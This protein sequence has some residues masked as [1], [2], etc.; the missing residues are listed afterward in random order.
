MAAPVRI[1]ELAA[2]GSLTASAAVA[3]VQGNDTVQKAASTFI[4]EAES[5]T[6]SG[7]GAASRTAQAKLRDVVSIK[8][9]GVNGD[10]SDETVNIQK[11]IDATKSTSLA[12]AR[13][14]Y[15][16]AGDYAASNLS[17][18]GYFKWLGDGWGTRLVALNTGSSAYFIASSQ[19]TTA[20]QTTADLP[21][22]MQDLYIDA[23]GFKTNC[24]VVRSFYTMLEN[25]YIRG[26]IDTDLL[27]S[28]A[29]SDGTQIAG[30]M[31]NGRIRSCW[32][33]PDGGTDPEYN[34]RTND[35][36][37][38][39]TDW[40]IDGTY[41]SG[42]DT[43]NLFIENCAGWVVRGNHFYGATQ[44]WTI[45]RADFTFICQGNIFDG[46]DVEIG[47]G[48]SGQPNMVFGPGNQLNDADVIASFGVNGSNIYSIGNKY[49]NGQIIHNFSSAAKTLISMDDVFNNATP[50]S[51]AGAGLVKTYN[52]YNASTSRR[53]N[54]Q[55]SWTPTIT[56]GGAST[57]ITYAAQTGTYT[58]EGNR[59]KVQGRIVLSSKG[60]LTGNVQIA[61][62]PFT[63]ANTADQNGAGGS[64]TYWDLTG[65]T[66]HPVLIGQLNTTRIT[67]QEAAAD[68]PTLVDEANLKNN[69]ELSFNYEYRMA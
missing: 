33:G 26:S 51:N 47:N 8:D 69:T 61:S 52:S 48:N 66:A 62:L 4:T 9:F 16:P 34:I 27:I 7:T 68:V 17:I 39:V 42:A 35:P 14:L 15:W 1:D 67:L 59:V 50:I 2:G 23:A 11:A 55:V 20:G 40:M 64:V 36:N 57:G 45:E 38:K 46:G 63:I 12:A 3:V 24:L 49:F 58:I 25:C 21:F 10:G 53:L 22:V 43:L 65:M 5:F 44:A 13:T 60:V 41:L 56:I 29:G 18:S 54:E 30:T 37:F 6:Q 28:S 19:Y 32:I 31:V